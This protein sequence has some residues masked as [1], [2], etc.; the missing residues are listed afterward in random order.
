MQT[1]QTVK[2]AFDEHR[3][4]GWTAHSG[5]REIGAEQMFPQIGAGSPGMG[6]TGRMSP[7]GFEDHC[8]IRDQRMLPPLS[9][10]HPR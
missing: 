6:R 10:R 7:M 3:A 5:L 8:R 1:L 4:R 2:V 9:G